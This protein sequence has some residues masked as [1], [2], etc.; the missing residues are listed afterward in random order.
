MFR[1]AHMAYYN[2][3]V[4]FEQIFVLT[5]TIIIIN[6]SLGLVVSTVLGLLNKFSPFERFVT[7]TFGFQAADER[8]VLYLKW[9]MS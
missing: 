9:P 4:T 2:I 5:S 8:S 1:N 7:L 3:T 6:C